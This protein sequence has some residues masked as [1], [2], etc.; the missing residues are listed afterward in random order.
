[1]S[2]KPACRPLYFSLS[3][4]RFTFFLCSMRNITRRGYFGQNGFHFKIHVE[5]MRIW[6]SVAGKEDKYFW[7]ISQKKQTGR[8]RAF[9]NQLHSVLVALLFRCKSG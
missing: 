9:L 7:Y 1:M 6:I 2:R 3:H 5:P 8:I 4:K